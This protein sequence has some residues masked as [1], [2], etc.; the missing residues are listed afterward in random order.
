MRYPEADSSSTKYHRL[1]DS[2]ELDVSEVLK[3]V[4][5]EVDWLNNKILAREKEQ[6]EGKSREHGER[7]G[8]KKQKIK[9]DNEAE[10]ST[11]ELVTELKANIN[12]AE[13]GRFRETCK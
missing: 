12:E 1:C 7:I 13:E 8:Q 6:Q 10:K 11:D 3:H 5:G 4:F 2:N 9:K